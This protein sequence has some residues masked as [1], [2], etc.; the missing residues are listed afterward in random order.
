MKKNYLIIIF[1]CF[2]KFGA[3]AQVNIVPAK[4]QT[5]P[6]VL[7]NATIH[8]G[9]GQVLNNAAIRFEN[10]IITAVG[11]NIDKSNAEE[12]NLAG[13]HIYPGLI[14]PNTNLGLVEIDAIRPTRDFEEAGEVN[15]H[16]RA[17]IAY[18][19]DS[20]LIPTI[21]ANGILLAQTTPQG[22]IVSGTSSVM[23]L[24]GWN[25]EDA[26][27]TIDVGIHLNWISMFTRGGFLSANPGRIEK[28]EN[29]Q[30]ILQ[31][32]DNIFKQAMA[33]SQNT[34]NNPKNIKFEAMR[35]L[36]DGSKTLFINVNF[37]REIVESV[38]F[39]KQHGVKKI[40]VTGGE[41]ALE[42]A[43]FLKENNIPVILSEVHRLPTRTED[44]VWLPYKLPFLLKQAGVLVGLTYNETLNRSRNLPFIAGTSAA[45]G[46]TK[47]EALMLITSNNAR[48]LGID[49]KVGTLEKGKQA[50]LV[51]SK[52]DL[53]DMRTS[54]VIHAFIQG[55]KIDLDNKHSQLY[56]KYKD[57]FD[58]K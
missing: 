39:A 3:F 55:K 50:T 10:G 53:L 56:K 4:A 15:P 26:A 17:L 21:R 30:A 44:D 6:I 52:G 1:L 14:L 23:E 38:L 16:A 47:E 5:K 36:Y 57:K 24:D 46:L 54:Q 28:N 37:G 42:V 9:N 2:F 20:E 35:G 25:W 45:Y 18:N 34:G 22:G 40:V 27:H 58:N 12:V 43:D 19:T 32:V 7:S 13:Q 49:S 51:V 41:G 11:E 48:I 29:R 8:I 33:Y 31:E